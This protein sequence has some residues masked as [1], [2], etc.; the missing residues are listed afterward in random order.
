MD[1][2]S[3]IEKSILSVLAEKPDS[4]DPFYLVD[5]ETLVS[6]YLQ[7]RQY[8]PMV[9]PFYAVK[10]NPNP[11]ILHT[12]ERLGTG[13]DC[14]SRDEMDRCLDMGVAPENLIFANPCKLESHILHAKV[15]NV[16][17]MTFD[18]EDEALKIA[19]LYPE[20]ELVLRIITDDSSSLCKFSSKFGALLQDA[21]ALLKACR[22]CGA[23][24]VGVSFHCG[25]GCEDPAA[26]GKAVRDA[27]EVFAMG[28]EFGYEMNLLDLGGGWQGDDRIKPALRDVAA[29]I[30]PELWR[31]PAG[32]RMIA[33]PGRYFASK[34]HTCVL[35][36]HSRRVIRDAAG[37]PVKVLYYVNDGVYQSFN[38]IFF[39]HQH[40]MP[41]IVP[42]KNH[43]GQLDEGAVRVP[44]TVFGPTCDSLDC[45]C[46]DLPMPLLEVGQW[47]YF[48]HMGAYTT[49]ASTRFNGFAGAATCHYMWGDKFIDNIF[50]VLAGGSLPGLPTRS[51]SVPPLL[52]QEP[53]SEVV[54]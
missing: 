53:I 20:A 23:R 41:R 49:A 51:K 2:A 29:H 22:D 13:F 11:A 45:I 6:Q 34:S 16:R 8:L 37:S 42:D 12:L 52:E 44:S 46:K 48:D 26:F 28:R 32:T 40:P 3:T 25:S 21:R 5:L 30:V 33:E 7:W 39:D 14:A 1:K 47:M 50:E 9:E 54:V 43:P 4:Q 35:R 31:F 27:A 17:K 38:C 18:N 24:V 15:R 19:R 10:C 36:V